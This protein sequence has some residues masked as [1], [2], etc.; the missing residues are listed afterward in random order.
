MVLTLCIAMSGCD[1][2]GDSAQTVRHSV[3]VD[4]GNRFFELYTPSSASA[5]AS[6]PLVIAFHGAGDSGP[7]FQEFAR[8]DR[9]ADNR[10]FLVAYP[11]ASGPNWAEGCNCTRPDIDGVDDVGFVDELIERV[12]QDFNVDTSKIYAIGYSQGAL[13][14]HRLACERSDVFAGSAMVAGMMSI[15]V[16]TICDP[17]GRQ[18]IMMM[19]GENDDVLPWTGVPSGLYATLSVLDTFFFWRSVS[20]CTEVGIAQETKTTHS[21]SR[22]V[23]TVSS[24][25]EGSKLRLDEI[26]QGG[27]QWPK[28]AAEEIV[29]FFGL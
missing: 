17:T 5:D 14:T 19:H 10:N 16:A 11:S 29:D 22:T 24:C 18:D 20:D 7:G 9:E 3:L 23:R 27:H 21:V 4:G 26:R 8:L 1:A 25:R 28:F 6:M 15:P 12:D 2:N 13:F